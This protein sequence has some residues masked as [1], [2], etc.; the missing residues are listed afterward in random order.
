MV[1]E[2]CM[3]QHEIVVPNAT[4]TVEGYSFIRCS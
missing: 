3:S 1:F 2:R 4:W